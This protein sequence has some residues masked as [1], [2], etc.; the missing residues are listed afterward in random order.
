M[1]RRGGELGLWFCRSSTIIFQLIRYYIP[2][3]SG[4]RALTVTSHIY[5]V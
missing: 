2:R 1:A 3:E 4:E 5:T